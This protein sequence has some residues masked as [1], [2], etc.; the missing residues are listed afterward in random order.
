MQPSADS[1][2]PPSGPSEIVGTPYCYEAA[3]EPVIRDLATRVAQLRQ[4][5]R[6][7]P[8]VLGRIRNFFRIKNIYHSN[9]I[10]GNVL[11]LG[12]TTQVVQMGLT[13]TGKPLK[14]QA[15]AKNLSEAITYL[16][17]LAG[18]PDRPL[19]ESDIRQLHYLVLKG[20][21][22][23]NAGQYRSGDVE[24]SGSRY[25]PPSSTAVS[26][27]MA[28]FGIW[29]QDA[30]LP[31]AGIGSREGFINA[32]V[33]HTWFVYIH[34]FVDGNGRVARLL[35][36]VML[37]R[38][39][40]P[41]AIIT[42]EDRLRYYD[43]LELS[44]TSDLS[45]FIALLAE[46]IYES[47]EEY[48]AAAQEQREREEWAQSLASKFSAPEKIRRTNEYEVWRAAMDLLKSYFKQTVELMNQST[49][50]GRIYFN[51]FGTLEVEKYL[52]LRQGESVK[53]TWF[54]RL[55]FRSG[56]KAAR[57]L[58][59]FGYPSNQMRGEAD[60]TLHVGRE[61]PPGSF[62]Y[63]RLESLS[64]PNVPG[65]VEIGYRA[66]DE[67]FISRDRSGTKR[68]GKIENIG[69]VFLEEV[70]SMHFAS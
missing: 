5:G 70:I 40:Y 24:I 69:K 42:K 64:S 23:A 39:G 7:T 10:E 53:K 2:A 37:M 15:E 46:S 12:E 11:S 16:E 30:S 52:S 19:T 32:A 34:P 43:A 4:G 9:A 54:F 29:L 66:K 22:D 58:F 41:I 57:Y 56:E 65:L 36:N 35:M 13:I 3:Q 51:D 27:A 48:E 28:D 50:V 68:K 14:D 55:D 21:N 59:F 25:K 67:Q 8:D 63:Q 26:A 44:Q 6:L 31:T 60:V 18:N 17:T 45:S 47:L 49:E 61:D 20:I 38:Y 1:H 62:F 33:A